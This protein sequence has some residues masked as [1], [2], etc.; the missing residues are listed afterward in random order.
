MRTGFDVLA[1]L[2]LSLDECEESVPS[3][4]ECLD[5]LASAQPS[6]RSVRLC[7]TSKTRSERTRHR[8]A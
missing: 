2:L 5:T 4:G 7:K 1:D 3:K 8:A 6:K